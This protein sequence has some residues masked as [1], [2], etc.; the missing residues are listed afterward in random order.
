MP[1]VVDLFMPVPPAQCSTLCKL[2]MWQR[3]DVVDRCVTTNEYPISIA[4][5]LACLKVHCLQ[6]A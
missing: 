5:F 4:G 6:L 1:Q 3:Y 2:V